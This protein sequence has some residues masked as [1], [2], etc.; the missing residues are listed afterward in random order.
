M[1]NTDGDVQIIFLEKEVD[2][3]DVNEDILLKDPDSP[4]QDVPLQCLEDG[5]N[6]SFQSKLKR[7]KEKEEPPECV[8]VVYSSLQSIPKKS[9]QENI[10]E[11]KYSCVKE[12]N[13]PVKIEVMDSCASCS[14]DEYHSPRRQLVKHEP[15]SECTRRV[16]LEP[17]PSPP[18]DVRY[19][20][21]VSCGGGQGGEMS[22]MKQLLT[23]LQ[24]PI[25]EDEV[26]GAHV[27]SEMRALRRPDL[28]RKLKRIIQEAI[29]TIAREDDG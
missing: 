1:T 28:K 25:D 6:S 7:T 16:K 20:S 17:S 5:A 19:N 12:E 29:L 22:A 21:T 23:T 2:D 8:D 14:S 27:A 26:F 18:W 13:V 4:L 9:K 10:L 24:K 11:E 3:D 15:I